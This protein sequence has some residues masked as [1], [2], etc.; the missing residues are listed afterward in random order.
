MMRNRVLLYLRLLWWKAILILRNGI[1]KSRWLLLILLFEF[2]C[3]CHSWLLIVIIFLVLLLLLASYHPINTSLLIDHGVSAGIRINISHYYSP[4][5]ILLSHC[6][7]QALSASHSQ[8]FTSHVPLLL[9]S[10]LCL[11]VRV[12]RSPLMLIISHAGWSS[13]HHNL[14]YTILIKTPS[15][16]L[17]LM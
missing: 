12:S 4:I 7:N 11:L 15:L 16:T 14:Y 3:L 6:L 13:P 1:L 17:L 9:P 5:H 10:I 8:V 2:L